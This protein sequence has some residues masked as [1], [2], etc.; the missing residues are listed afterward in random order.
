MELELGMLGPSGYK[1]RAVP[2]PTIPHMELSR[3]HRSH[4]D[5]IFPPK[6]NALAALTWE[7]AADRERCSRAVTQG[8][9]LAGASQQHLP[10]ESGGAEVRG[11]AGQRAG[12]RAARR[13]V[14]SLCFPPAAARPSTRGSELRFQLLP[15]HE[16]ASGS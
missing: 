13:A 5:L 2:S 11:A 1:H 6:E 8:L 9:C 3:S 12:L 16:T 7:S 14:L 4:R 10:L 15:K